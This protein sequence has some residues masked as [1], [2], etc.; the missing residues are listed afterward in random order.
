MAGVKANWL[1]TL[2]LCIFVGALGIH[3]FFVGKIGTGL[4]YLFTFGLFGIGWI[5]DLIMIVIGK[6]TTKSGAKVAA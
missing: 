6:F 5:Y 3:R 2:L 4:L 1:I